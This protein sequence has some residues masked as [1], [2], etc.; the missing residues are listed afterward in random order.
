MKKATL[1]RVSILFLTMGLAPLTT[2]IVTAQTT[3][4]DPVTTE[5]TTTETAEPPTVDTATM[6]TA[7]TEMPAQPVEGQITMQGENTMLSSVLV[8]A[9][10]YS[11]NDES[12]GDIDD[13]IVNLDGTV[14]GAV[15][16][17]GGFLGMGEKD[18]AVEMTKLSISMTPDNEPRLVLDASKEDLEAAPEFMSAADQR[19][20]EAAA[21]Q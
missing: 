2:N 17:V 20:E 6:E 21:T 16:G 11:S 10:V 18:V 9:T 7:A 19:T 4:A 15:I 12:I 5:P 1:D 14:E 8:G 13:L 3:D